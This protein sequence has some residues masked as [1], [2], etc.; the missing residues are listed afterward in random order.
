MNHNSVVIG[1]PDDPNDREVRLAQVWRSIERRIGKPA[2]WDEKPD[3][4]TQRD[5]PTTTRRKT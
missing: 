3:A 5:I 2:S 1:R 4:I